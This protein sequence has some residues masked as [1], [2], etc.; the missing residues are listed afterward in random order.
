MSEFKIKFELPS[1][2]FKD[3]KAKCIDD[4]IKGQ[5]NVNKFSC[6]NDYNLKLIELYK[7]AN[8]DVS[9]YK[10]KDD[11]PMTYEDRCDNISYDKEK[12][13]AYLKSKEKEIEILQKYIDM[14]SWL[15]EKSGNVVKYLSYLTEIIKKNE[16]K[17]SKEICEDIYFYLS[18]A[19]IDA[20]KVYGF[21]CDSK[22]Q[23]GN[24]GELIFDKG[25]DGLEEVLVKFGQLDKTSR[26]K[27]IEDLSEFVLKLEQLIKGD[28][29]NR[30]L[31]HEALAK[32][33]NRTNKVKSEIEKLENSI[34]KVT[35]GESSW[36]VF[37]TTAKYIIPQLKEE[38]NNI[39]N[40]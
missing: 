15:N 39:K 6:E 37:V 22:E 32:Y 3:D 24:E 36:G 29:S 11:I 5:V 35:M 2:F 34:E 9:V 20:T 13:V 31:V 16:D 38:L 30:T 17:I 28:K 1:E 25:N 23:S 8:Y 12:Y 27:K 40:T 21:I 19:L 10:F 4:S 7:K 14:D 33:Q 26:M 18:P